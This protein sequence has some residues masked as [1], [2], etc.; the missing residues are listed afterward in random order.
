VEQGI[1]LSLCIPTNGV[2][3]W[4]IPVLEGIYAEDV[5][6]ELF[7]VIVTDNGS[8]DEFALIMR[9]YEKE[10]CN[11]VYKRTQAVQFQNQI[12]AFKLAQGA[13]IKFVNHRMKLLPGTLGYF[14]QYVKDNKEIEPITYFSN[15]ALKN[16]PE[17]IDLES[18]NDYVKELSYYSSWSA[19]TAMWKSDFNTMD[20]YKPF[21]HYFPHID[22]IFHKKDHRAYKIINKVLMEEIPVDDTK[23]GKYDLFDAFENEYIKVLDRLRQEGYITKNT[24]EKVKKENKQLV[25]DLYYTYVIRKKPC[26]YD[27][28]GFIKAIRVYYSTWQILLEIPII[29]IKRLT[30]IIRGIKKKA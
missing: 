20:L 3:E 18:F 29:I 5:D 26:S 6:I 7:E 21:N 8:N 30:S 22:M 19:G 4:V 17:Y 14:I 27:L 16:V 9:N 24:F 25:T 11:F 15:G 13:L 28:S 12:E 23:K 1:L 10:Y 2:V